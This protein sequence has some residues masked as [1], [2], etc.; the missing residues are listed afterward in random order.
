M[1]NQNILVLGSSKESKKI[2][3]I[4]FKKVYAS[5]ASIINSK[6][7]LKSSQNIK[8]IS[9]TTLKS[10]IEDIPTKTNLTQIRPHEIVLRK[11][12][13]KVLPNINFKHK[14]RTFEN[15]KQWSFQ[16]DFF[17]YSFISLFLSE[18]FYGENILKKIN[19][20][21]DI[22]FYKKKFLGVSTGFF[23][24]LLALKE[25]PHD[26]IYISGISMANTPHFYKL[27]GKETKIITRYKVD[28]FM[29][30]FLKKKYKKRLITSDKKFAQMY[31]IN[32]ITKKN[33]QK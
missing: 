11:G 30:G 2:K 19:Y 6:F 10:V 26:N 17:N 32:Y 25:N 29:I 16:K 9:V 31:N 27:I 23:S 12:K 13:I 3:G 7:Y 8:I 14:L 20:I 33:N 5:N 21:K 1:R 24:I 4:K 18:F 22:I 15:N 28:S